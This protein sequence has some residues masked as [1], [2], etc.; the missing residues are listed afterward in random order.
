MK[1]STLSFS[2]IERRRIERAARAC[3]WKTGQAPLFARQL[4]LRSVEDIL[5]EKKP[6]PRVSSSAPR[7]AA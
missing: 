4:L 6:P 3:G 1:V 7:A 5:G 2:Q